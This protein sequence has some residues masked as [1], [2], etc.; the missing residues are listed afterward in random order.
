MGFRN[1]ICFSGIGDFFL[2]G[3]DGGQFGMALA[4]NCRAGTVDEGNLPA[5]A[6]RREGLVPQPFPPYSGRRGERLP[7]G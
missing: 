5:E 1:A 7:F 2:V 6:T 4:S 3:E